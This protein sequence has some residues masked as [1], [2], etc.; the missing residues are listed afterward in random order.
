MSSYIQAPYGF[1]KVSDPIQFSVPKN[2]EEN[3]YLNRIGYLSN[4][5]DPV[6]KNSV[7]EAVKL[8]LEKHLQIQFSV[9]KNF[10]ENQYLN[11][12]GYLSNK[13]DPVVK[14]SVLEAVKLSLEKHLQILL[15]SLFGMMFS[16]TQMKQSK[17]KQNKMLLIL[18]KILILRSYLQFQR[19]ELNYMKKLETHF[20]D[21]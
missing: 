19:L 12:I 1:R 15:V 20:Q 11:R 13:D 16:K 14:N 7:L 17:T 10:E 6:V 9:P 3:Q 5:D 2:F 21:H 8:S 18:V 4:K